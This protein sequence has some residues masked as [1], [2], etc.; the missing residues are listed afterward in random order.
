MKLLI[1]ADSCPVVAPAVKLA[2]QY[3]AAVF[4]FCD[5]SHFMEKDGAVTIVVENGRDSA[6]FVLISRIVQGDIVITG[7]YGLAAIALAKGAVC[8]NYDGRQYTEENIDTL[9]MLRHAASKARRASARLKGAP[10]R[11]KKQDDEFEESLKALL[12]AGGC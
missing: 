12:N 10:K 11:T 7:D 4:L 8:V 2:L 6:D 3:G 5:N 1:D 9:L